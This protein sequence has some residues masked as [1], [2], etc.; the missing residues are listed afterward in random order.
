M[1]STEDDFKGMVFQRKK[2]IQLSDFS[3]DLQLFNVA[4]ALDGTRDICT[5]AHEENYELRVLTEKIKQLNEKGLIESKGA[6]TEIADSA[7]IVFFY[8]Q[9]AL[10]VGPLA[11]ILIRKKAAQMNCELTRISIYKLERLVDAMAADIA[12]RHKSIHF[13]SVMQE[14]II[15]STKR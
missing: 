13:K 10:A 15:E 9:Y 3:L 4:M 7:L 11:E 2:G 5:I 1:K 12:D 8:E 6:L 14:K